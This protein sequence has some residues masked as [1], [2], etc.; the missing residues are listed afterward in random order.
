MSKTLQASLKELFEIQAGLDSEIDLKHPV[1]NDED[2][3]EKKH[4]AL[5]VELGEMMN[6]VREFKFWSTDRKRRVDVT[7]RKCGG[8]GYSKIVRDA[9]TFE[10]IVEKS[11]L[12]DECA[13]TGKTD[14]VLK[15]L[16]DGLHF[17]LSIGIEL[18]F[19]ETALS[20][21]IKPWGFKNDTI[22]YSFIQLIQF[23]WSYEYYTEGLCLFLGFCE[24]LGYTWEQIETAYLEKNQIN[25]RRLQSGY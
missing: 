16:V 24:K 14:Y 3:L 8:Y 23:G 20:Q 11:E 5:L 4:T 21:A 13:G 9:Q 1:R 17:V 15:E 12:C 19:V 6:E 18:D 25:H 7:C 22:E 10:I 2:R